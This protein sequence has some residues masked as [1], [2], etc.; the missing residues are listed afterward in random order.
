M[1]S[2]F[3]PL[4]LNFMGRHP[5]IPAQLTCGPFTLEDARK[6]GIERWHL[7]GRSWRRLGPSTY[8]WA[9]LTETPTV[10]LAAVRFRLPSNAAFSGRTAAWLH[11]LD[12]EPCS[13]IE[14]TVPRGSG[15]SARAG[16]ALRRA[17][18]PESDVVLVKGFRTTSV[19]RTLSDLCSRLNLTEAV[20]IADMA[21][22]S[23]IV[24][25]N[26]LIRRVVPFVEP[27]SESPME[28]RLRM[29][30]VLGGLPR[31]KA[32]VPLFDSRGR[33]VGRPDLYYPADRLGIEYDGA[34]H[35]DR[36]AE[37]NRRQNLLLGA[38]IRLLRFTAGDILRTPET[39]P[40]QVR[41]ML[42]ERE[43]FVSFQRLSNALSA[44]PVT[45]RELPPP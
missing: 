42:A 29:L 39:V 30:L 14:V 26:G 21:L 45:I 3:R 41:E 12:V 20:V 4:T 27:A 15:V 43:R 23:R 25:P 17:R 24:D 10:R 5:S 13:P 2:V 28:S 40:A 7:K 22:H 9:G 35:R 1:S 44:D 11:G 18:L 38:G 6:A 19:I 33:F 32:Q 16:V 31:P 36:L 34:I 37:D 8:A